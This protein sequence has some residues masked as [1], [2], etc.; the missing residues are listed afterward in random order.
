MKK[1]IFL[2]IVFILF[3]YNVS[4]LSAQEYD[5]FKGEPGYI[6]FEKFNFFKGKE[7][8]VELSIKLSLL[9]F[10]AKTT[11]KNDP[12]LSELLG[13]LSLIKVDVFPIDK[14]ETDEITSIINKISG[15]LKSKNWES[16]VRVKEPNEQVEIFFQLD[17]DKL[18]GLVVM[19]VNKKEAVF[20]NII[21]K[22]D[23]EQLGKLSGK[24]N[25]PKLDDLNIKNMEKK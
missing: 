24:F 5:S 10:V 6:D 4:Y 18:S 7:K 25:I 11:E 15:E 19:A 1:L 8:K 13:N 14:T 3:G 23:P 22:I 12:E 17:D 16:I 2:L 20:V 9:K 21:G